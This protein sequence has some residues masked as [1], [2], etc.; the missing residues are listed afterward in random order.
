MQAKYIITMLAVAATTVL[1]G[2]AAVTAGQFVREGYDAAKTSLSSTPGGQAD[3]SHVRQ[4]MNSVSV[5]QETAPIIASIGLPPKEKSGNLQGYTC[6][7][8]AAVYSPTEDA[9]IVS[10]DGKVVFYGNSTCRTEMQDANFRDG[11][12][13]AGKAAAGATGDAGS[14]K[15]AVQGSGA[16]SSPGADA[17]STPAPAAAPGP[18]SGADTG[19]SPA[20]SQTPAADA[21]PASGSGSASSPGASGR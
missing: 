20:T 16:A 13:Y 11:G 18:A 6:Y 7:Q 14:A 15:G 5:G 2:C 9:V 12:K 21:Q 8:Y 17:G 1:A 19:S 3:M 10:K 4:V